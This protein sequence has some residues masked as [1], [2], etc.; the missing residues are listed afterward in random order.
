MANYHDIER[1][2]IPVVLSGKVPFLRGLHGIGK[3][4]MM[5]NIAEKVSEIKGKPVSFHEIDLAHVKEGELTGMPVPVKDPET[6]HMINTYTLYGVFNEIIK[7]SENG[8]MPI[9]FFDEINRADKVVFNE[10]M[11]II[12]AKR[13]QEVHLPDELIILCAG[14][15]EDI[16]KYKGANDD[17]AVLPMDPALKDRLFIFEL[18]VD[19]LEWLKWAN[20]SVEVEMNGETVKVKPVDE[21]IIAFITEYPNALHSLSA[22]EINPTP[23]GWKM[24]SDAYKVLKSLN[25]GVTISDRS[26][27]GREFAADIIALG[28]AKIGDEILNFSRFLQDNK[29]PLI[30][31]EDFFAP[32]VTEE[33]FERALKKL[34]DD[35]P[36]RRY[37]SMSN[38]TEYYI[39]QI[40]GALKGKKKEKTEFVKKYSKIL[41]AMSNDVTIG[42]L[43]EMKDTCKEAL[44]EIVLADP[45]TVI[46]I[47]QYL[48]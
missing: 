43:K 33:S 37:I 6:G 25:K 28:Q 38:I 1:R 34:R 2:I 4:E 46:Q 16:S 10:L 8:I 15:P 39:S 47:Q 3:S 19:P 32:G 5:K 30:K 17:Y 41:F 11:P 12:L 14:N 40:T 44:S 22:K 42:C 18:E 48:A 36:P 26:E 23:R 45:K 35:T 13:V 21:D 31:K 9:I 29:N 24:F 20:K 27:A 7:E